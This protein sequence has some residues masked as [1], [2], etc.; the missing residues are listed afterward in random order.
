MYRTFM[1]S[2]RTIGKA[3]AEVVISVETIRFYER[4]GLI[5]RPR[6]IDG[7]RHY[8][9]LLVARLRYIKIA[10][11][12]GLTLKEIAALIPAIDEGKKFCSSLRVT[13]EN[14]V[15]AVGKSRPDCAKWNVNYQRFSCAAKPVPI[16]RSVR[17]YVS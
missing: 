6:T 15:A 3:A 1:S 12:L 13:V 5:A 8:D 14:K 9:E 4:T 11:Q 7:P 2:R 17:F 10:Q 16:T